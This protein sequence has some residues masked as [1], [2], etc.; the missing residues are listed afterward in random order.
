MKGGWRCASCRASTTARSSSHCAS[1]GQRR[2][3]RHAPDE[4][5]ART[6]SRGSSRRTSATR[7]TPAPRPRRGRR[8]RAGAPHAGRAPA[9][10]RL[11]RPHRRRRRCQPDEFA[12]A[13][14]AHVRFGEQS[15]SQRRRRCCPPSCSTPRHRHPEPPPPAD[16]TPNDTDIPTSLP[17]FPHPP[18]RPARRLSR[19]CR[20]RHSRVWLRPM[21]SSWPVTPAPRSAR[22]TG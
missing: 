21:P 11:G 6:S 14:R 15:C 9:L 8:T 20:G 5:G 10:A 12:T 7:N 4:H 3:Y 19:R 17:P 18:A 2:H 1:P 16:L 22:R 13:L